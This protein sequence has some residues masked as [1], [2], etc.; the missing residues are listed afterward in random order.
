[1]SSKITI[2]TFEWVPPFAQGYVRDIRVRWLCEE[3]GREYDIDTVSVMEKPPELYAMQP[4]G[5][6]PIIKDGDLTLFESGAILMYLAEGT[7]L[8]PKGRDGASVTQWLFAAMNSIE[9]YEMKWAGAKFFDKDEATAAR[10]ET[11]LR[12]RLKLL[13]GGL[14]DREWFAG[15]D[16][17]IADLLMASVLRISAENGLLDDLPKL[18]AF[19]ERATSR[20]AYGRAMADHMAHWHK[21]DE[22]LAAAKAG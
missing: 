5:Q 16:F 6:V 8:L 14:G 4:F 2:T 19:V 11:S 12:G 3:I 9:P 13:E 20:P 15:D 18:A 17:T 7:P 21:A 10:Y 22:K 1:M